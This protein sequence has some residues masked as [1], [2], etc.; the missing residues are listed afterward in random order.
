MGWLTSGI[1]NSAHIGGLIAGFIIGVYYV[2][3]RKAYVTEEKW[4]VKKKGV[5]D[6]I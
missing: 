2:K 1:D 6:W 4:E 3:T 5:E